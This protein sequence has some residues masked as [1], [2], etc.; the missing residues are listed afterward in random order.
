M[1]VEALTLSGMSARD[2]ATTLLLS[3]WSLRKWRDRVDHCE[4][5]IDWRPHLYPSAPPILQERFS[6]GAKGHYGRI[7]STNCDRTLQ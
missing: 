1:Q 4:V 5:Q 3:P 6:V 2:Y 7:H